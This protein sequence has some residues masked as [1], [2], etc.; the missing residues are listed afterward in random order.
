VALI[1]KLSSGIII[2]VGTDKTSI[3]TVNAGSSSIKLVLFTA[4]T[5]DG[6]YERLLEASVTGIGQASCSLNTRQLPNQANKQN[7]EAHDHALA[8]QILMDWF[9]QF[10]P[11]TDLSLIGHRVVH[12]GATYSQPQLITDQVV[13]SL[14]AL[15]SLDPEHMPFTLLLIH[16]LRLHY[17]NIPQ[18]ACFDTAFFHNLP[19]QATILPIPRKF[20]ASGLRRYG[21]HGLSYT[22]L[23]SAFRD[24]AGKDAVNGRVIYAHLG[25]GASLTATKNGK[26]MDTTMGFSPTSGIMMS[27]RS[28]DIDPSIALFLHRQ[29]G[30]NFDEFNHMVNFESGLLGVSE[31]S[32]D[33]LT[34]LQ[35]EAS[36]KKASDAV[37]LFVYQVKKAIGSLTTTIGGLDSL[38]FSG[39]IGEQSASLRARI[40]DGLDYLGV[41][42]DDDDNQKHSELISAPHSKV[43]VHVIPTDE[44]KVIAS[45]SLHIFMTHIKGEPS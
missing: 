5:S 14:E 30:M 36:N 25:S 40:C 4:N 31:L 19:E 16:N 43:G 35:H 23:M 45:E 10:S 32:A 27:S 21:F 34:L 18:V 15:S 26:P 8:V 39:G 20:E 33:M 37:N 22:Y 3:L 17:P 6:S 24:T 13:T 7:I 2:E 1:L 38:V 9:H 12:G 11:E 28:G 44:A 29:H 41:G 42:I